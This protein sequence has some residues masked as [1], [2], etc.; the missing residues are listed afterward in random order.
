M[1]AEMAALSFSIVVFDDGL[2]K[3]SLPCPFQELERYSTK[4][5]A[6]QIYAFETLFTFCAWLLICSLDESFNIL[7]QE[8]NSD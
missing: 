7:V 6:M 4:V 1:T 5:F 8:A 3:I 2:S